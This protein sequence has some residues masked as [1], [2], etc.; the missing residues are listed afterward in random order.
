MNIW[1]AIANPYAYDQAMWKAIDEA[2]QAQTKLKVVFFINKNS[3]NNMM[4]ELG[5]SGWLGSNTLHQLQNS[6]WEGYRALAGDVLKR[7]ERKAKEKAVELESQEVV[8]RPTL[9]QYIFEVVE[10]GATKVIIA[11]PQLLTTKI[12]DLPNIAE[13]IEE[14]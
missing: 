2:K 12:G 1:L 9:E 10:Q 11:G 4:I 3:M 7:V 14:A 6:M 5:E 13:Y 8:E